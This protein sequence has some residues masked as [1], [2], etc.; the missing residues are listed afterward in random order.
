[1]IRVEP[2]AEPPSFDERVRRPGLRALAE[3]KSKDLLPSWRGCLD[4]LHAAYEGICAYSCLY[5]PRVVGSKTTDHFSAKASADLNLAYEWSNYRLACGLMNSRKGTKVV[6]DP[7]TIDGNWFQLDLSTL[8]I[9]SNPKL[10]AR[11][12]ARVQH[13][14]E[15]LRLDDDECRQAR[16]DWYQPYVDG[17]ITFSFLQRKCPFLAAEMVRQFGDVPEMRNPVQLR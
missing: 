15:E 6:I 3:I 1:V 14:I 13:T 8:A 11:S 5:I 4:D 10:A 2:R 7:F 16:A 17:E 9:T 12:R